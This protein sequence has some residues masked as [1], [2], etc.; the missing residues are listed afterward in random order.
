MPQIIQLLYMTALMIGVVSFGLQVMTAAKNLA[1]TTTWSK[2]RA[3]RFFS[4]LSYYLT[5]WIS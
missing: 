3:R 1:S 2:A 4:D 5:S